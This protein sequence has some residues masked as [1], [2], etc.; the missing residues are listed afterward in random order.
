MNCGKDGSSAS[1]RRRQFQKL[2][3]KGSIYYLFMMIGT[4]LLI[5]AAL[6]LWALPGILF[7]KLV[8][9]LLIPIFGDGP[10]D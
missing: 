10:L 3:I 7:G 5:V 8:A 4:V 9:F 1:S 2:A 6:V